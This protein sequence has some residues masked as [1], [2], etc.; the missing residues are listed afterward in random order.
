MSQDLGLRYLL[1]GLEGGFWPLLAVQ[2]M[3]E[4]FGKGTVFR[5]Y[6]EKMILLCVYVHIYKRTFKIL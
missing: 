3:A 4:I 5:N 6:K 1:R 2:I